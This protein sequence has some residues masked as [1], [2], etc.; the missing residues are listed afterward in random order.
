[1]RHR[2]VVLGGLVVDARLRTPYPPTV[3]VVILLHSDTEPLGNVTS[4]S[5]TSKRDDPNACI[6]LC[7]IT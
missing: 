7:T 6:R 5:P 1:M 4:K 2:K 3:D